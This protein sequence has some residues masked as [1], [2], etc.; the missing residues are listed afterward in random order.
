MTTEHI[1]G[2]LLLL[3]KASN[4][5]VDLDKSTLVE[6]F[7]ERR[8]LVLTVSLGCM[9]FRSE[10]E[11]LIQLSL[12]SELLETEPPRCVRLLLDNFSLCLSILSPATLCKQRAVDVG[13]PNTTTVN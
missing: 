6:A 4:A 3:S 2:D 7:Q 13:L 11:P 12:F 9:A 8:G 1:C 10:E 5:V